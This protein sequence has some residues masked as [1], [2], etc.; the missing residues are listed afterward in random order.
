MVNERKDT[1]WSV[2]VHIIPKN[3]TGKDH[4]KYYVGMTGDNPEHRY[5]IN[6]HNYRSKSFKNA[7]NK[8][9][10]D[11]IEHEILA[12]DLTYDEASDFEKIMIAKLRSNVYQYGYN[13]TAGNNSVDPDMIAHLSKK[14]YQFTLD[15]NLIAIYKSIAKASRD[16]DAGES[17]ICL[18]A[19]SKTKISGSSKYIWRFE[20]DVELIDGVYKMKNVD[21]ILEWKVYQ[22]DS[23]GNFVRKYLSPKHA[24]EKTGIPYDIIHGQLRAKS[25]KRI[26]RKHDFIWRWDIDVDVIDGAYR[27]KESSDANPIL[28]I[29]VYQFDSTGSFVSFYKNALLASNA[30]GVSQSAILRQVKNKPK[31]IFTPYYWRGKEDVKELDDGSFLMLR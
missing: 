4:D 29:D 24:S 25:T 30:S 18:I 21:R 3:I 16:T 15:G 14:V 2:Y 12:T 9:G 13:R 7:I 19:N 6:G 1:R 28:G 17:S 20:K 11:N 22:F 8:Y 23:N 31:K 5:G 10:W 26:A 27:I